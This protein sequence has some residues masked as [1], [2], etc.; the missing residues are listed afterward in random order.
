M[1][2][3]L[4]AFLELVYVSSLDPGL[5]RELGSGLIYGHIL[6]NIV[7]LPIEHKKY[8][9][10][11]IRDFT[12]KQP[13]SV[14]LHWCTT[15]IL[16][17]WD[18]QHDRPWPILTNRPYFGGTVP[19]FALKFAVPLLLIHLSHFSELFSLAIFHAMKY[20][21][22]WMRLSIGK[23]KCCGAVLSIDF[24]RWILI[25]SIILFHHVSCWSLLRRT[26]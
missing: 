21:Y 14:E 23:K 17:L 2:L 4:L 10:T 6:I 26:L 19:T 20:R 13:S 18:D 9:T 16:L 25:L 7:I 15:P 11:L 3:T 22:Q 24:Y 12:S 8:H 1:T 5:A